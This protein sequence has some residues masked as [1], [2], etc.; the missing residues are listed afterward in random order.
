MK[1]RKRAAHYGR[2]HTKTRSQ[3]GTDHDSKTLPL[4]S[5]V[6][7]PACPLQCRLEEERSCAAE[8]LGAE[9]HF[10]LTD[11]LR[12]LVPNPRVVENEKPVVP[13]NRHGMNLKTPPA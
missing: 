7:L 2:L 12:S 4:L 6:C 10:R 3:H 13:Q 9:R 1:D 11:V 8:N 5:G